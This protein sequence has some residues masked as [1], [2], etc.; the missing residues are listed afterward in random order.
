M[1]K[2]LKSE[3]RFASAS[4]PQRFAF[5]PVICLMP[6]YTSYASFCLKSCSY[7]FSSSLRYLVIK[8]MENNIRVYMSKLVQFI[9]NVFP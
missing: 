1:L 6:A 7:S 9:V 3:F 4:R 5:L 2:R 8:P